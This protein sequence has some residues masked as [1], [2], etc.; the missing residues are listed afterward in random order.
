[1]L[2]DSSAPP[3]HRLTNAAYR[4]CPFL[5]V[6]LSGFGVRDWVPDNGKRSPWLA[7]LT[8]LSLLLGIPRPWLLALKQ[9]G[10]S[11]AVLGLGFVFRRASS[12]V[13]GIRDRPLVL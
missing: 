10:I 11:A 4:L 1:M 6:A 7:M 2:L 8:L 13:W 12:F 3:I 5:S 9:V